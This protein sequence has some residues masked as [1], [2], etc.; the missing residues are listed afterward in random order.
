MLRMGRLNRA[1]EA[2]SS[3]TTIGK[4]TVRLEY[5]L[6]RQAPVPSSPLR[7]RWVGTTDPLA[8]TPTNANDAPSSCQDGFRESE[9]PVSVPSRMS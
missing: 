4:V 9:L 7:R 8:S 6:T 2:R 3:V 1:I 5:S